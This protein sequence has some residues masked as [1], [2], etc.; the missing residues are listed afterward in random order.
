MLFPFGDPVHAGHAGTIPAGIIFLWMGSFR[1][2]GIWEIDITGG[3]YGTGTETTRK[4]TYPR[5][6]FGW[7][8]E[9]RI[10]TLTIWVGTGNQDFFGDCL[11]G[12]TGAIFARERE[13]IPIPVKSCGILPAGIYPRTALKKLRINAHFSVILYIVC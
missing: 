5:E 13:S 9:T 1:V 11:S 3:F 8:R 7:E 4:H 10:S 2:H 12:T 6:S